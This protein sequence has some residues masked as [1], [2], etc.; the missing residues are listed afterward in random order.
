VVQSDVDSDVM[1]V[2]FLCLI[3]ILGAVLFGILTYYAIGIKIN[4]ALM[5]FVV[6]ALV[7]AGES[8]GMAFCS[9][10]SSNPFPH[11]SYFLVLLQCI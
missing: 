10:V 11:P 5:A 7:N 9:F 2:N 1:N 4:I 8:M 6:F 3:E